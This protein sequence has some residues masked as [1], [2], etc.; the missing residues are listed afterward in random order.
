MRGVTAAMGRKRTV[1]VGI[2]YPGRD[3]ELK[4][5]FNDVTRMRRC[6]IERF[7]FDEAD[8]RVLADADP[9]F[10][11][12]GIVSSKSDVYGFGVLL[13]EDVTGLPAAGG[14]AASEIENLTARILPRVRAQGVE[15]LVDARLGEGGNDEEEAS[16]RGFVRVKLRGRGRNFP[17]SKRLGV[18][19][20]SC[21]RWFFFIF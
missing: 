16:A 9:F 13:L 11:R 4:G 1:L 21:W 20:R 19:I 5:C 18:N 2:N 10:L 6:L 3:D 8:I 17:S 12:T 7:G 14:G 15:G